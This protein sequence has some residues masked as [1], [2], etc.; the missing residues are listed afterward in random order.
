MTAEELRELVYRSYEA[1][2]RGDRDFVVGLFHDD[3]QWRMLAPPEALPIPNVVKG[4]SQV[5]AAL[6]RIDEVVEIVRNELLL[7]M[8]DGNRAAVV[9]D[10]V[11]RQRASG[12]TMRYKVAA[13]QTYQDGKLCEYLAFADSV[14]LLEQ[15]LGRELV[16]P[17]AYVESSPP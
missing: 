4:K 1:F 6:Q 17:A 11:L 7:V 2:D 16:L 8:V 12:R 14:D 15:E 10:R 5:L 3:I 9:C 13:F